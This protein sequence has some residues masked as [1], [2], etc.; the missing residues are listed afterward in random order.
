[1]PEVTVTSLEP[2]LQKQVESARAAVER[3]R[4]DHAIETA[5]GVLGEQPA[6]LAVRKL[7]HAAQLKQTAGKSGLFGRL[8][9][10]VSNA[11]FVFG[12]NLQLKEQPLKA[13]AS[14]DKLLRRDASNV[15]ALTL[16]G[17]AATVFGWHETAVFA[18]EAARE[19]EPDRPE[20]VLSLG[21]ALL[22][23]GR[24]PAAVAA[25]QESLRLQPNSA[26][27]QTLLRNASIAVTM[28]KGKWE[29][30]GDYRGKLHDEQKAAQLEQ[31][32]K[33][34]TRAPPP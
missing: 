11:P 28:A 13:V 16:L 32:A 27:A 29:Q 9:T 8:L 21:Q 23:V 10:S 7:L 34:T 5:A 30:S 2:R 12:G 4:Y 6:C 14:A 31:A 24:A 26:D 1:M 22:A 33:L 25:A 18:Y 3:G 19:N 15:A 20:L 17:Q